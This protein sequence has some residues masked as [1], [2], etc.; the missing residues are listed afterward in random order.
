MVVRLHRRRDGLVAIPTKN[1]GIGNATFFVRNVASF[2][3]SQHHLLVASSWVR[4]EP[5]K[6]VREKV[7]VSRNFAASAYLINDNVSNA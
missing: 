1:K 7:G 2:T 4:G 5:R 3:I 6:A